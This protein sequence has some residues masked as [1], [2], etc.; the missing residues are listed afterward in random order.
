MESKSVLKRREIQ[1]RGKSWKMEV[2]T[3]SDPNFYANSCAFATEDEALRAGAELM[4]RWML[5]RNYRAVEST[6]PVNCEFPEDAPRPR[7][8]RPE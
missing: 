1:T 2:Q 6:E 7:S 4:S 8:L 5:V 3:G